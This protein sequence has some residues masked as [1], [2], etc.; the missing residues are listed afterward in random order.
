MNKKKLIGNLFLL[1]MV[2]GLGLTFIDFNLGHDSFEDSMQSFVLDR[3]EEGKED[4]RYTPLTFEEVNEKFL[5]AK[6]EVT[7]PLYILAD[8]MQNQLQLIS[9]ASASETYKEMLATAQSAVQTLKLE[10]ISSLL[11]LD[12]RLKREVKKAD[13]L[14]RRMKAALYEEESRMM[15]AVNDLNSALATFNL[16]VFSLDFEQ[17]ET[18]LYYHTFL[19]SED[20]K[21]NLTNHEAIF[22]LSREDKT[23]V[24][25][26]EI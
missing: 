1:A 11:N 7:A 10:T 22:E 12:A 15:A 16:S 21:V 25:F 20:D 8:S 18:T 5:L 19:L 13:L 26:R 17:S 4:L 24:S 6:N 14:S 2:T 23:V 9:S 3:L